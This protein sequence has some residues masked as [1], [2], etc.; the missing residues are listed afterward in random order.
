MSKSGSKTAERATEV[1]AAAALIATKLVAEA[2]ETAKA[3]AASAAATATNL[4]PQVSAVAAD[5]SKHVAVCLERYTGIEKSLRMIMQLISWGGGVVFVTMIGCIG[6][7][8]ATGG[9]A[10]AH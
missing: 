9:L 3:L 6:W 4:L 8:I 1:A 2:A 7:F 5:L 10:R